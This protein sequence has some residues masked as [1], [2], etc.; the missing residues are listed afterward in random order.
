M[1][2]LIGLNIKIK[3]T[4]DNNTKDKKSFNWNVNDDKTCSNN[5]DEILIDVEEFVKDICFNY[6]GQSYEE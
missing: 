2:N 5:P 1:K 6:G 3:A 4:Y